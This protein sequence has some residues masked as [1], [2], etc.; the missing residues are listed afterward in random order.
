MLTLQIYVCPF[1]E[2]V[3]GYSTA[4]PASFLLTWSTIRLGQD[5]G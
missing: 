2:G 1:G 4:E 3:E 5:A